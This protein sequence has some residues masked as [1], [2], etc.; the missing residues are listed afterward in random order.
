MDRLKKRAE[1]LAVARGQRTN[2]RGFALQSLR[3]ADGEADA[4]PR[5][6]FTLTKK[7]GNAVVRN[8][9]RRRLKEAMRLDGAALGRPGR[10]HV[11]IGRREAL[12]LGFAELRADLA[13]AFRQAHAALDR[14][15]DP[16]SAAHAS[17]ARRPPRSETPGRTR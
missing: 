5:C 13:G 4:P 10:A 17:A 3:L 7:V 2:R 6:G 14:A 15:A 1:F 16:S 8:R 12:G 11:L 9:I